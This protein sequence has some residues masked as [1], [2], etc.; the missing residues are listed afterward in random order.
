MQD[1][2]CRMQDAGCRIKDQ[3]SRIGERGGREEQ[4]G[5]RRHLLGVEA[6]SGVVV[7]QQLP[8][9][10]PPLNLARRPIPPRGMRILADFGYSARFGAELAVGFG[11]D[12][13]DLGSGV[14]AKMAG[15]GVEWRDSG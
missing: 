3:G 10:P 7:R 5:R 4:R 14:R 12:S 9:A 6:D 2:G 8:C 15:F 11:L 1:A 13:L